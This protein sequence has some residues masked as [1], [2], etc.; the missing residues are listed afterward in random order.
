MAKKKE[1]FLITAIRFDEQDRIDGTL[2]P[3]VQYILHA[4]SK[5]E[6]VKQIIEA[7]ADDGKEWNENFKLRKITEDD[8]NCFA[9]FDVHGTS[10]SF[11]YQVFTA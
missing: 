6:A 11:K 4:D 9:T 1:K 3:C 2:D 7:V 5:A 8:I 10:Y